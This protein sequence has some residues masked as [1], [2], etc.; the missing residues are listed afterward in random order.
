MN[1]NVLPGLKDVIG[2][3][4]MRFF[5][6]KPDI[7]K[8]VNETII[9]STDLLC[10]HLSTV[11]RDVVL[12]RHRLDELAVMQRRLDDIERIQAMI[13]KDEKAIAAGQDALL[14]AFADLLKR[15]PDIQNPPEG[16][17][18]NPLDDIF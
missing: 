2:R 12:L 16:K 17:S 11:D 13:A 5:K 18:A 9:E 8:R 3:I 14:S 6:P 15:R 1:L 4:W 10:S 7:I